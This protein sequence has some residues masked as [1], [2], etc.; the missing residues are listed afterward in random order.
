[1]GDLKFRREY[2]RTRQVKSDEAQGG[3]LAAAAAS[4]VKGSSFTRRRMI[5]RVSFNGLRPAEGRPY[6][7]A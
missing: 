7:P 2:G 4:Q 1:M 5:V 6:D 3:G